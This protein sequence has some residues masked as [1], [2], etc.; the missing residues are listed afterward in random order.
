MSPVG[1]A[2]TGRAQ[3][4]ESTGGQATVR[5]AGRRPKASG[6]E[7]FRAGWKP[8]QPGATEKEGGARRAEERTARRGPQAAAR[9]TLTA[10]TTRRSRKQRPDTVVAALDANRNRRHVGRTSGEGHH[11]ANITRCHA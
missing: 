9:R 6:R 10:V 5:A 4:S 1:V 11:G 8:Q 3:A 7:G 2:S